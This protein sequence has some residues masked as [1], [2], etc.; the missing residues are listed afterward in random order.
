MNQNKQTKEITLYTPA[1]PSLQQIQKFHLSGGKNR[2]HCEQNR[3]FINEMLERKT[4]KIEQIGL[5]P[6]RDLE[7]E[8]AVNVSL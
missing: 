4:G 6:S 7:L 8:G 3:Q 5:R 1:T 2:Q